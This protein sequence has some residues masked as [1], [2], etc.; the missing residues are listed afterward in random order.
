[1]HR[2]SQVLDR[3]APSLVTQE[4]QIYM[5][6]KVVFDPSLLSCF[7]DRYHDRKRLKKVFTSSY[8]LYT[9]HHLWAPRQELGT[10]ENH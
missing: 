4:E 2:I 5:V 3:S 6:V 9:V 7:C 10:M 1:M 8:R